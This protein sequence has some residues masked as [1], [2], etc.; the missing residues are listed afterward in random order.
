[1]Q[2]TVRVHRNP[3]FKSTQFSSSLEEI[4]KRKRKEANILVL[5]LLFFYRR[6]QCGNQLASVTAR[7]IRRK[8]FKDVRERESKVIKNYPQRQ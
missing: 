2:I 5:L 8:S 1:M 3:L 6:E 7:G 4:E